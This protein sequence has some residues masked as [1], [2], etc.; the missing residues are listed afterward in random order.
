MVQKK[1]LNY[2]QGHV[3]TAGNTQNS[4]ESLVRYVFNRLMEQKKGHTAYRAIKPPLVMLKTDTKA[5]R[6]RETF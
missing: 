4:F 5:T 3:T 6:A 2:L 1:G